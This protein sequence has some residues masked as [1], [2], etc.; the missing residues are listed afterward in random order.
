MPLRSIDGEDL[1]ADLRATVYVYR[2]HISDANRY[3]SMTDEAMVRLQ[4]QL[5]AFFTRLDPA[6]LFPD[7]LA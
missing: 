6:L 1:Y 3:L 4:S 5:I 7:L 2:R